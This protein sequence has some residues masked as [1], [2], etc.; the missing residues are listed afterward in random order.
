MPIRVLELRSVWGFG[1]GP[2]KTILLGAAA[3]HARFAVCVCYLRDAR[4]T[5]FQVHDLA[6][7]LGVDYREILE[8]H[9]FDP[10][11]LRSLRRLTREGRFDIVHSHDYKTDVLAWLVA[12]LERVTP[13]AT[14]HGWSGNSTWRERR[15][16]YPLDRWCLTRFPRVIAVSPE[17][18][19]VLAASGVPGER[20]TVLLNGVDPD[21]FR[22]DRARVVRAREQMGFAAADFVI[23][24]LGRLE[25]IKR[26][27][28]L[29]DA[30][31]QV[32]R[33]HPSVQLVIAG[34]GSQRSALEEA[35]DRLIPGACRFLGQVR[36]V[37]E[38]H[39]A[40]DCFVQSSDY[41]GTS[42]ALL[43]AMA[44]ETPIVATDVGGTGAV[45]RADVDG[46]LVPRGDSAGLAD[47]IRRTVEDR[48]ATSDRVRS[49]RIRAETTLSFRERTRTLEAI[50]EELHVS[51]ASDA[52]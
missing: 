7:Q 15:L 29:I 11:I 36:D 23:G 38:V 47:A 12:R 5:A 13:L 3:A 37:I 40:L 32:R 46:L 49:S 18:R 30:V 33:A 16:Y 27:D 19:D 41:E 35:A 10:R 31:A 39:H 6:R 45:T 8:R 24:G 26:F 25:P 28:L 21:T 17:I 48:P 2:E 22:R 4:D 52:R 20:M 14:A 42:N 1:G 50:Y 34:D 9:S 51:R 44:M 43:E